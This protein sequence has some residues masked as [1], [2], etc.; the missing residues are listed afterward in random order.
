VTGV[1]ADETHPG[2]RPSNEAFASHPG[3]MH[4]DEALATA[5]VAA[6]T[7]RSLTIAVAESLTGGLLTAGLVSVPGASVVLHGG[8]IAYATALKHS[9]LGVSAELLAES[10]PVH[11]EVA[12]QMAVGVRDALAVDGRAADV[13]V[14]TTGV[15][16]PGPQAGHP[17]GTGFIGIAIGPD[18]SVRGFAF[19]GDR[20]TIRSAVVSEVLTVLASKLGP[21]VD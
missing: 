5:I 10:G 17:A 3:E 18:V 2:E 1:H 8:V 6:L 7:A 16:G 11:P 14:A 19:D 15:A 9:L 12:R 4:Q 20:E 13:G 21:A